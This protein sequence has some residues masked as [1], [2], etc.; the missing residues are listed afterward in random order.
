MNFIK[1]FFSL[2]LH[3]IIIIIVVIIS[4][5]SI[6]FDGKNKIKQTKCLCKYEGPCKLKL[7]SI[8]G[9]PIENA[10]IIF[11]FTIKVKSVSGKLYE[12][13]LNVYKTRTDENGLTIVPGYIGGEKKRFICCPN[14]FAY[15][16]NYCTMGLFLE[17]KKGN[18]NFFEQL[19]CR[20][21]SKVL[22][23]YFT[24]INEKYKKE[25]DEIY[26]KNLPIEV[27]EKIF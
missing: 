22:E 12:K 13:I 19:R 18:F 23:I 7:I 4:S 17:I 24:W 5:I 6:Q 15:K 20:K 26:I 27:R 9:N 21:K 1:D 2:L 11:W 3:F 25:L 10:V 14:F 16:E 8:E